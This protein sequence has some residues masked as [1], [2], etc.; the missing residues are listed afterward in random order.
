MS[1]TVQLRENDKAEGDRRR[2]I[3]DLFSGLFEI[4]QLRHYTSMEGDGHVQF[5]YTALMKKKPTP[6]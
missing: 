5:F 4:Q 6:T 2:Q 3:I 1:T